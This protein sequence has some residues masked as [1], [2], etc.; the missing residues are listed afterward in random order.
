MNLNQLKY[1]T[2]IADLNS[3]TKASEFLHI[4]QPSLSASIKE[5]ETEFG[6]SLFSRHYRG[7]TLTVEGIAF[8]KMS[9]EILSSITKA[10]NT[11][12]DMGNGRKTLKL[13]TPPMIGSLILPHI[14]N[15]FLSA[16]ADI[17]LEITEGGYHGLLRKLIDDGL[18]MA[19][20][21][22]TTTF[23]ASLSAMH[24]AQLEIICCVNSRNPVKEYACVEPK[25][26]QNHPIVLFENHFLQ[27]KR[28]MEWFESENV[29]P[30]ILLQTD[31]LSTVTSMVSNSNAVGFIFRELIDAHPNLIPIPIKKPMNTDVSLLWKNNSRV[32][33]GMLEFMD[34][35]KKDNPFRK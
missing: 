11:M 35:I 3:I 4:S 23:E 6:V 16:R 1:F 8:Y 12:K 30:N 9:K 7:V 13:G 29:T 27:N 21:P 20:L 10:E 14:Y 15:D 5:L 25:L 26:L 28:I 34:Y 18:D 17:S 2:V 31:Q 22:H 24:V 19:I 33:N 32:S